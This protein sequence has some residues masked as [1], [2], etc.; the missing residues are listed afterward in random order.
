[1]PL[2]GLESVILI[3]TKATWDGYP[4]VYNVRLCISHDF[5]LAL[6]EMKVIIAPQGF[7]GGI[8]GLDAAKAIARGV[9][10]ASPDAETVLLPVADGGDGTLH[11]LV[12]ATG[13][14]IF[15][16]MVI[17]PINQQVAAQWG[18]MGD[19]RTAVIEM[20]RASGLAMVP[21]R[22]RNPRTTTTYGTGQLILEASKRG[23]NRV[24]VGLGGSATND[25]GAGMAT[26]LG[27]KFLDSLGKSLPSGGAALA[28]LDRIDISGMIECVSDMEIVA[29]TDVTNPLCG[30]TGASEIFGPQKGAS[31]GVVSELDA[32][33][34]QFAKIVKRDLLKDVLD[35]PG[36][37]AAGGLG[38][39]LIAFAG[40]KLR[41]GIDMVC[42]V[43][44][45]DSHL[46]GADLVFTG[47]GRAD[48]ST[49]FD[50]APVGVARHAKAHGIPTVLLA[51]SLGEG[52]EE[53]YDHGVAS[54]MCISD[55]TMTFQQAL[56]RT[57]E[58]L[59]GTAE[60]AMRLFLTGRYS[61]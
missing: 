12:D 51:G 26:A 36:A 61:S 29:A 37:G 33:L 58:M 11:A 43:L 24:I 44:D 18:V 2:I 27:F 35:V 13:G 45:F 32:A 4:R 42:Q 56:G 15:T 59:Q 6:V 53:L 3:V 46:K 49:V 28:N 23:L 9:I 50:K 22:R 20:A 40:A 57:G 39:G 17:G 14:E 52:H 31:S 30:P 41:S 55:G 5:G 25:G 34:L 16:S 21:P 7:K 48:L 10:A 60:R 19:G 47:E 8:L 1:M 54:V 38:A